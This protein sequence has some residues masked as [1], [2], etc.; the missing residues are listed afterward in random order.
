MI[1]KSIRI[2]SCWFLKTAAKMEDILRLNNMN[3]GYEFEHKT[4]KEPTFQVP[5]EFWTWNDRSYT[6]YYILMNINNKQPAYA[7]KVNYIVV[8]NKKVLI[9]QC[10]L[11]P[12]SP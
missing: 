11:R 5:R 10:W 2:C 8:V 9:L 6:V 7:N 3:C 4:C 1:N 12:Y